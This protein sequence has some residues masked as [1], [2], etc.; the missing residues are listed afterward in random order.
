M[1][2]M[3]VTVRHEPRRRAARMSRYIVEFDAIRLEQLAAAC[4]WFHPDFLESVD[5]AEADI[6]AGRVKE[7]KSFRDFR[8][9]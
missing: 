7:L 2:S 9:A 8:T 3:P 4:G 5:R 1:A 6:R